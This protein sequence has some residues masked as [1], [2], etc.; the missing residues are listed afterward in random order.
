[1]RRTVRSPRSAPTSPAGNTS[2]LR[3]PRRRTRPALQGPMPG[4]SL[5][6]ARPSAVRRLDSAPSLSSPESMARAIRRS[7]S[8]FRRLKP[9]ARRA[10]SGAR[11]TAPAVGNAWKR[12]PACSRL[13]PNRSTNRP[14]MLTPASRLSCWNGI[15]FANASNSSGN[16]GGRIP[17]RASAVGR[18]LGSVSASR[19]SGS[20][21]TSRPRMLRMLRASAALVA[22]DGVPSR[23]RHRTSGA[24]IVPRLSTSTRTRSSAVW[25][26]RR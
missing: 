25:K 11:A 22:D 10:R 17:R 2:S 7:D 19:R 12:R 6:I 23:T 14:T 3:S 4:R 15:T 9:Q 24:P 26:T 20:G 18:S 5:S 13:A 1:M 21:S 16:R 8:D